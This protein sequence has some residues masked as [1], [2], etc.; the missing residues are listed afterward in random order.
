MPSSIPNVRRTVTVGVALTDANSDVE[1]MAEEVA[2][3]RIEVGDT[4]C[5]GFAGLMPDAVMR[6]HETRRPRRRIAATSF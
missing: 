5:V 2:M 4:S 3:V 6:P 1:G